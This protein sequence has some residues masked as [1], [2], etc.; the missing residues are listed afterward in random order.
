MQYENL[1]GY[2]FVHLDKSNG[3][4]LKEKRKVLRMT[5][6][7]IANRANISLQQYQKFESGE[8]N[9]K[10]ASFQLACRVIEALDMNIS[11][12]YHGKYIIGEELIE[13]DEGLHYRKSGEK[14]DK[15]FV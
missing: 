14:I 7:E 10:T 12:F 15:D 11:D 5:Q 8:R 1:T 6:Q 2:S 4:I 3:S 13:T 9:I